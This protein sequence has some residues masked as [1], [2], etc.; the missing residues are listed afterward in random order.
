MLIKKRYIIAITGLVIV[1]LC[2]LPFLLTRPGI[3]DFSETGQI[4]DTI[5]GIISPFVAIIAAILTFFAFYVQYQANKVQ[6]NDIAKERIQNEYFELIR[7]YSQISSQLDVHGFK[8]KAAFAELAGEW[9]YTYHLLLEIFD[10]RIAPY[11]NLIGRTDE[12]I[13]LI[14]Q[15]SNDDKAKCTYIM[16]LAYC[17]YFYGKRYMVLKFDTNAETGLGETIKNIAFKYSPIDYLNDSFTDYL[18]STDHSVQIGNI[19][20]HYPLFEGHSHEL[21]HYYRHLFH[22]VKYLSDIDESILSEKE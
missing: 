12:E 15:L 9:T 7:I 6:R 5:G 19:K 1:L 22:T 3:V 14:S 11:C 8:G 17:L 2:S 16:K 18:Y 13:E 4:G 21:G 10:Q 20:C